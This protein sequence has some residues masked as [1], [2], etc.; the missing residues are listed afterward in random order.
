MKQGFGTMQYANKDEYTGYWQADVKSG[1]GHMKWTSGMQEYVGEWQANMPNG[2]GTHT[3]FQQVAEPSAANHAL[4]LMFNRC[5]CAGPLK[6]REAAERGP[7]RAQPCSHARV[8]EVGRQICKADMQGRYAI[9]CIWESS[10]TSV[11]LDWL[12]G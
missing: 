11:W 12:K 9:D 6:G 5:V 7:T 8:E 1:H 4:L 3:W 10:R 2:I